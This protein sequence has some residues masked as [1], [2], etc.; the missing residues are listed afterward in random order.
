[1]TPPLEDL[2]LALVNDSRMSRL[3]KQ[4]LDIS[5]PTDVL[6]FELDHDD[7]GQVIGGE[8]VICISQARRQAQLRSSAVEHELLLYAIHGMLH[9][10][11]FDDRT[12]S[13]YRRMHRK[14]DQLLSQLGIGPVFAGAASHPPRATKGR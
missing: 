1:L 7:R 6:T 12:D 10:S 11:G 2:S 4:F 5:G 14:E 13:G 9:L 8:V 3:H